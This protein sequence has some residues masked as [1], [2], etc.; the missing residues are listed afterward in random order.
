MSNKQTPQL[1][2]R[3][4]LTLLSLYGIGTI[5]GAGIYVLI[6]KVAGYAGMTTPLAFMVAAVLAGL[7][8]FSYAE[9]VTRYPKS[10]AE[11]V[12]VY[13]AFSSHTLALVMGLLIVAV[14]VTSSATLVNGLLGY[15]AEFV[16]VPRAFAILAITIVLGVIVIWGISQSVWIASV[17]TVLE[18]IGLLVVIWVTRDN[19]SQVPAAIPDMLAVTDM[20]VVIGILLGAFV[21]FYAYIGFE[22]MVN[23]AEEVR[24]PVTTLPR[25]IMIALFFTATFYVIVAVVSI[26]SVRPD[27]LAQSDAPLAYI[28]KVQTGEEATFIGLISIIS[29]LNGALVQMIMASRVLYGMSRNRWLPAFLSVVNA[30]THTPINASLIIIGVILA[31]SLLLPLLSLAKITSFITLVVF[32]L[33]NLAL[34]RIKRIHGRGPALNLPLWVPICGFVFCSGFIGFQAY[35]LIT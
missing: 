4:N 29:I 35:Q 5:L 13:Q 12:Y 28:Y 24:D 31:L 21:A 17:L 11:A 8:A 20:S 30:R 23:V 18:V 1:Q 10:A 7:S 22:D 16:T 32:A 33:I 15:L 2:R 34:W 27:I 25:G 9:L 26:V 6:G 19:W 3:L 14:G